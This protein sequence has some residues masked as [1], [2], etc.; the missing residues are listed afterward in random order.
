MLQMIRIYQLIAIVGVVW[1]IENGMLM[2]NKGCNLN[3]HI[4]SRS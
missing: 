1:T 4:S 3:G 2:E